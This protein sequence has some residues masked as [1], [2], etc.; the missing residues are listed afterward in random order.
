[1]LRAWL[2]QQ[3]EGAGC[4]ARDARASGSRGRA[5][6]GTA[7]RS[8]AA[9]AACVGRPRAPPQLSAATAS[10]PTSS[11]VAVRWYLRYRLSYADVAEL[12]A[13]RGIHVD[14]SSVYDWVQAFTPL[15]REAA[16]SYRHPARGRWAI[17]ETYIK[18]GGVAQYVFRAP[19]R[20]RPGARC[21]RRPHARHR[22]GRRLPP[23]GDRGDGGAPAHGDHRQGGDL[24]A[25]PGCRAPRSDPGGRQTEQQAIERDHQHLK[26]RYLPMRGFKQAP[27]AQVVCAGHGFM[28]NLRDGFYR[29]GLAAGDPPH[30]ARTA[31]DA[32]LGRADRAAPGGLT[33]PAQSQGSRGLT[34]LIADHTPARPNDTAAAAGHHRPAPLV[35]QHRRVVVGQDPREVLQQPGVERRRLQGGRQQRAHPRQLLGH[36]GARTL[37]LV[38]ARAVERLGHHVGQR[39]GIGALRPA[40]AL[41]AA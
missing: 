32:G 11:R 18:V 41:G 9:P 39:G 30:P 37:S 24:P 38:Q 13:E 2:K 23:R 29:L 28:R 10:R 17:D 22:S 36:R 34:P 4:G 19:G 35:Q 27:A 7:A 26:G 25:R 31:A 20:A 33:L 6:T 12:L 16:R 40:E 8:P 14:P 21:L 15:Y 3:W 1:M 5:A